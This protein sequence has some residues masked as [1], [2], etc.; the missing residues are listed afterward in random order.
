MAQFGS[1]FDELQDSLLVIGAKSNPQTHSAPF[2]YY[3]APCTRIQRTRIH[4][5]LC[6]GVSI[7]EEIIEVFYLFLQEQKIV[8]VIK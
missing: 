4:T 8:H 6:S 7:K 3:S 1:K 5:H 2:D